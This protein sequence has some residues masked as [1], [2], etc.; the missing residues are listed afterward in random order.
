MHRKELERNIKCEFQ[1]GWNILHAYVLVP[2]SKENK[3]VCRIVTENGLKQM[4][5]SLYMH[6]S[7]CFRAL[8]YWT[9]SP[10]PVSPSTLNREDCSQET[11]RKK[12]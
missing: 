3:C 8:W 5:L 6:P 1:K 2:C 4:G 11:E 12:C 10:A 7:L 9:V